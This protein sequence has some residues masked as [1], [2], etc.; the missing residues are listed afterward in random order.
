MPG[1]ALCDAVASK[2]RNVCA[3]LLCICPA[4]A[5]SAVPQLALAA[6]QLQFTEGRVDT[7]S[8]LGRRACLT[9]LGSIDW[10]ARVLRTP[11]SPRK[12]REEFTVN[13][14]AL[15][16]DIAARHYRVDIF[17]A[18]MQWS[19]TRWVNGERF[20]LSQEAFQ[21]AE[22]LQCAWA[23][24]CASLSVWSATCKPEAVDNPSRSELR[25]ALSAFDAA[26]TIFEHRYVVELIEIEAAARGLVLQAVA[27]ERKLQQL[28]ARNACIAP[29][30]D[31]DAAAQ[32]ELR[33]QRR[34]LLESVARL[35]CAANLRW[36]GRED[37]GADI[38]ELALVALQKCRLSESGASPGQ[39]GE[40][41]VVRIL[42]TGVHEA[43]GSVRGYLR[44]VP[45]WIDSV[46]PHL[47]NNPGLVAR[48]TAWTESWE[49]AARYMRPNR[50]LK[51]V[52][53]LVDVV[54]KIRGLVPEL[55][56]MCDECDVELFMV[57]PRIVW[58]RYLADP[59][60]HVAL[61]Q[62]LVPNHFLGEVRDAE[63]IGESG[64]LLVQDA[65]LEAFA[66]SYRRVTRLLTRLP[67]R[68]CAPW[69][70]GADPASSPVSEQRA[71]EVLVTRAIGGPSN[72]GLGD[73]S[74]K[75]NSSLPAI[76]DASISEFAMLGDDVEPAI[77]VFVR[78]LERW[79]MKLQRHSPEDWCQC[80]A[81]LV[82]C[83]AG[84]AASRAP[85]LSGG[86]AQEASFC[87]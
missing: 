44:E 74:P 1:A 66:N 33:E 23:T 39:R 60:S 22:G 78:D 47:C 4:E 2:L 67:G 30:T 75:S 10:A 24:L 83:V 54:H 31:A 55:A 71:W 79:S 41:D 28:E 40:Q 8:P 11:A 19:G 48:M 26:W 32:R 87:V 36:K 81:V 52:A 20:D 18:A 6:E 43:F 37:L 63:H 15:F 57:L 38:L 49:L 65:E 80:S 27:D 56:S 14:R 62:R 25:A 70:Q 69:C 7:V 42:T 45:K 51:A 16:P 3:R 5:D 64:E 85:S 17:E 76:D 12:Y 58:L 73:C 50:V 46:H 68:V 29:G 82:R 21:A 86:K 84:E 34:R 53:S 77:E 59:E 61:L 35:N 13:Y 9:L 72:R